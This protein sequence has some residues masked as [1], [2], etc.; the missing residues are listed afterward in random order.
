MRNGHI[1]VNVVVGIDMANQHGEFRMT[2]YMVLMVLM[3]TV[4]MV[5]VRQGRHAVRDI[6]IVGVRAV[7]IGASAWSVCGGSA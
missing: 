2:V 4:R 1:R 3:W 5:G 6:S 7:R